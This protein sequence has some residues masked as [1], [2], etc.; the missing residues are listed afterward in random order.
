MDSSFLLMGTA[1]NVL[2]TWLPI[3]EELSE[4]NCR[5]TL[6]LPYSHAI[7]RSEPDDVLVALG[8][9]KFARV[10]VQER[11][12]LFEFKTLAA[13]WTFFNQ[14]FRQRPPRWRNSSA[15]I[16][17]AVA[18]SVLAHR[19]A[20]ADPGAIVRNFGGKV[21]LTDRSNYTGTTAFHDQ[22]I[23][24]AEQHKLK[25]FS[26]DHSTVPTIGPP[27]LHVP[28]DWTHFSPL[29]LPEAAASGDSGNFVRAG[30]PRHDRSWMTRVTTLSRKIHPNLPQRFALLLSHGGHPDLPF[31]EDSKSKTIKE[32]AT[33][34]KGFDLPLVIRK[35]PTEIL[36]EGGDDY[37]VSGAHPLHLISDASVMFCFITSTVADGMRLS[38]NMIE[39]LT[40]ARDESREV[41]FEQTWAL[42]N[43][44]LRTPASLAQLKYL[45]QEALAERIAPQ[46]IPSGSYRRL[47]AEPQN[48]VIA[49][50]ILLA[51]GV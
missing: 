46:P 15:H 14:Q 5:G 29:S 8:N 49:K 38:A 23:E 4:A 40:L 28:P 37:L 1:V 30:V 11:G 48:A 13:A 9:T 41:R 32:L 39:L 51:T 50:R 6:L 43:R 22:L 31:S 16:I 12:V 45:I 34:L 35:H 36:P 33:V 26:I 27:T 20:H 21:L 42:Q 2:D 47:L 24:A 7:K 18:R 44:V 3:V 25:I 10:L 19:T 17:S